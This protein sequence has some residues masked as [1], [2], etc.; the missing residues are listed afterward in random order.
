MNKAK[1][2]IVF[3]YEGRTDMFKVTQVKN[4][5]RYL[6][7]QKLKRDEVDRLVREAKVASRA[8]PIEV[9]IK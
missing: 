1:E 5:M 7:G 4:T 9:V 8:R 6:P 3:E 2:T